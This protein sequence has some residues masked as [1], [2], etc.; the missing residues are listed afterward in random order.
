MK[1]NQN[2]TKDDLRRIIIALNF[3]ISDVE[4]CNIELMDDCPNCDSYI[5]LKE[6]LEMLLD[7]EEE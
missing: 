6:K 1:S 7:F 4:K 5:L 3:Y 2:I